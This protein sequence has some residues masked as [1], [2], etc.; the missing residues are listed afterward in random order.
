[1]SY[2]GKMQMYLF[3][4]GDE[5][6]CGGKLCA[7]PFEW[8]HLSY[9]KYSKCIQDNRHSSFYGY[10]LPEIQADEGFQKWIDVGR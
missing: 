1:M 10:V 4:T 6:K 7:I 8:R 9:A 3:K 2:I 5:E